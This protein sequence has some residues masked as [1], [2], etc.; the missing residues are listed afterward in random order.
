METLEAHARWR[1][2]TG[3]ALHPLLCFIHS[4]TLVMSR[5]AVRENIPLLWPPYD[6]YTIFGAN[7]YSLSEFFSIPVGVADRSVSRRTEYQNTDGS[8]MLVGMLN[9]CVILISTRPYN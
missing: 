9:Q 3:W 4:A 8:E 5:E 2:K 7:H 6:S 1:L